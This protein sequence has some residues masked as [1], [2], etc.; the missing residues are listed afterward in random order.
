[1]NHAERVALI[2]G[3]VPGPGGVWADF[4]AGRGAFTTALRALIGDEATLFAVDRDG[5]ALRGQAADVRTVMADF[6][7]EKIDLPPLDGLLVAN[8]LHFVVD[9][10]AAMATLARYLKPGGA[11]MVVEYDV[12]VP[13]GY[14]PHPLG[15]G[16][17]VRLMG[18][19]GLRDAVVVG[20]RRS[21]SSGV[22]MVAVRAL[23]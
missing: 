1:M 22:T 6:V 3:G 9:Q 2:R 17:C 4:G 8:A 16:R 18:E 20:E 7:R 15:R 21:P 13:R 11:F 19:A 14:I 23:A 10:A 12:R 5:G